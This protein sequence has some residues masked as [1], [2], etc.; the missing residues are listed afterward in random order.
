MSVEKLQ[1]PLT[2]ATDLDDRLRL[3]ALFPDLQ[4]CRDSPFLALRSYLHQCPERLFNRNVHSL[5]LDWLRD[6]DGRQR[7][8]LMHYFADVSTEMST[9]LLF[10]RQVNSENWHDRPLVKGDD[11]EVVRFIDTVLHPAYLR[12]SEGVLAALIRPVAHFARLD[13]G[14]GVEGM[15]VFNLVQELIGG[16]MA[17]CV[18]AY[19]HTVRNGIGHGGIT[20]LQNDIRYR[21]KKGNAEVLDVW[22]VVRLCDDMVDTCNALAAAIKLFLIAGGAVGYQL[23]HELLVEELMEETRSPW[24]T[25]SGCMQSELP[26]A[27]QLLVYARPE[28]RDTLKIQ[29]A[30]L[31]SAVLAESLAPGY[32]RYFFS[33][34]SG[35]GWPGWAAFDGGRLKQLRESGAAEVHEYATAFSD[36]GFFYVPTPRLPRSLSR[37]DTLCHSLRLQWPRTLQQ[38]RENLSLPT[39]LGREA[40]MHRNGWRYVLNGEVVLPDLDSASAAA[41]IHKH[42]RRIV[43]VAARTA[44]KSAPRFSIARY[45]PLGYARIAV[46]AQ[47]FRQRRLSGFGLGPELVC[48]VQLRRIRR[49]QSPDIMGST[50]EVSG[51]WRIA[52]NRSWIE[53]G[54][55][56]EAAATDT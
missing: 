7:A 33:L 38:I 54:G 22:S 36:G 21:D 46:F 16:P 39:V 25:I 35:K 31:Q 12:L 11:Y 49:I 37:M 53:S 1:N 18:E 55:H 26:D 44:R 4:T 52:W 56:V 42:R 32:D 41:A 50:L 45:L 5:M 24:W 3:I 43:R 27:S 48:T 29:W 19:N 8:V 34:P 2:A 28:S 40:R 30:A 51:S 17:A 23:P 6:R 20:Y 14:K 47:D 10:L 15:D 13:R 9:A